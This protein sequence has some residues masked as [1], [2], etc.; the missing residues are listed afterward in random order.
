[1]CLAPR[2]DLRLTCRSALL[3]LACESSQ[4]PDSTLADGGL[5]GLCPVCTPSSRV[6]VEALSVATDPVVLSYADVPLLNDSVDTFF[7]VAIIHL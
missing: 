5:G 1:M 7:P 6:S 2:L 4:A 3:A